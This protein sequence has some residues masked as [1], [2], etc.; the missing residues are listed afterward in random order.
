MQILFGREALVQ[1]FQNYAKITT[2][3]IKCQKRLCRKFRLICSLVILTLS[4]CKLASLNKPIKNIDYYLIKREW[5]KVFS[6]ES[7]KNRICLSHLKWD[8]FL[9]STKKVPFGKQSLTVL[10]GISIY[11]SNYRIKIFLWN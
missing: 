7:K 2:S 9:P 8:L 1:R 3:P 4:T 6:K 5:I 10:V 11:L